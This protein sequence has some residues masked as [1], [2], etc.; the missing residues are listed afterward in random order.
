MNKI[1]TYN[2]FFEASEEHKYCIYDWYEDLKNYEWGRKTIDENW[3]KENSDH[4]IGLGWYEKIKSHVDKLYQ[5]VQSVDLQTINERMYDIWDQFFGA[6]RNVFSAVIYAD[7][8]RCNELNRNK[9]RGI[10]PLS[11]GYKAIRSKTD[12]IVQI[13]KNIVFPTLYIGGGSEV[14]LRD[15]KPEQLVNDDKYQCKNFDIM[16]YDVSKLKNSRYVEDKK[17][18]NIDL[19]LDLYAPAIIIEIESKKINLKKIETELDDVLESILP[20]LNYEEV[21]FDHS[22][23]DRMFSDEMCVDSYLAKILLKY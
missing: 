4:Y 22:R 3:L 8:N 16:N 21:I 23:Y 18:Y 14:L 10:L 20:E 6:K 13:M 15:T 1:K 2:L 17:K 19:F 9:F 11:Y 7:M 5:A 12:I